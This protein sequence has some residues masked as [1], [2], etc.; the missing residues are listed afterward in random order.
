[1]HYVGR[2]DLNVSF[3]TTPTL[4]WLILKSNVLGPYI[5][6]NISVCCSA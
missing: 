4:K 6:Y 5:V 1:M 2:N 3:D